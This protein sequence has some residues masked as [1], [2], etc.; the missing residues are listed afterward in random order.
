MRAVSSPSLTDN[1]I[2]IPSTNVSPKYSTKPEPNGN[3]Q[4]EINEKN[5]TGKTMK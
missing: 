4:Q 1:P 5:Y 3:V 2:E